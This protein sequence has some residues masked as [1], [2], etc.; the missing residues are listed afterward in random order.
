[1]PPQKVLL[2]DRDRDSL[3]IYTLML[4]HHGYQVIAAANMPSAIR[5]AMEERPDVVIADRFTLLLD[6]VP[7]E[8]WLDAD[9]RT[10]HLPVIT[11]D[12]APLPTV[13]SVRTERGY[14]LAKPCEPSR[15]LGAVRELLEQLAVA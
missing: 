12:S 15:L 7:L 6:E 2:V 11:L 9:E 14:A 8:S 5:G 10:A 13:R 1:M 3:A 4:E